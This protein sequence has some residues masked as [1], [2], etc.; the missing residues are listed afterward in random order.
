MAKAYFPFKNNPYDLPSLLA[1]K[2]YENTLGEGRPFPLKK[3]FDYLSKSGKRSLL[4]LP[5]KFV[6]N[7]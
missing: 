3:P 7:F 1:K 5:K 6:N 4:I 2:T